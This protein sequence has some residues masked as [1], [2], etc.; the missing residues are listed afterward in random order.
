VGCT[1]LMRGPPTF[2]RNFTLLLRGHRCESPALLARRSLA[3]SCV[4]FIHGSLSRNV[5]SSPP[6][7]TYGTCTGSAGGSST[8]A[9]CGSS[10]GVSGASSGSSGSRGSRSWSCP[11]MSCDAPFTLSCRLAPVQ[12]MCHGSAR[13]SRVSGRFWGTLRAVA[14]AASQ[15]ARVLNRFPTRRLHMSLA[16]AVIGKPSSKDCADL[17]ISL[18]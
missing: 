16:D 10:R 18:P 6:R 14:C 9:G 11:G 15:P 5:P 13:T 7:T 2:A 12:S 3:S 8:G 4:Y 17:L 1:F